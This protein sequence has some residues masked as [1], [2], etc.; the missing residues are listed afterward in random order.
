MGVDAAL[1]QQRAG[2]TPFRC[3]A[4]AQCGDFACTGYCAHSMGRDKHGFEMV[5]ALIF[6]YTIDR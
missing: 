2:R 4:A 6:R 5:C 1:M 3:G